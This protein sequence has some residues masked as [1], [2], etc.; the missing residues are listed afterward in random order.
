MEGY[1]HSSW[2]KINASER[3]KCGKRCEQFQAL[4]SPWQ[5]GP[6][7]CL[8]GFAH[9]CAHYTAS[10]PPKRAGSRPTLEGP[11]SPPLAIN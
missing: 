4:P 11:A 5:V 7:S 6:S 2:L 1:L 9:T 3:L 10:W 8:P